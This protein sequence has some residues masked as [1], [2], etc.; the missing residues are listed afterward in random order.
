MEEKIKENRTGGEQ[1]AEM[2]EENRYKYCKI[3]GCANKILK[4]RKAKFCEYHKKERNKE[5]KRE[6]A[7]KKREE[8]QPKEKLEVEQPRPEEPTEEQE[9][10]SDEQEDDEDEDTEKLTGGKIETLEKIPFFNNLFKK[11]KVKLDGIKEQIQ[12]QIE[13]EGFDDIITHQ[14]QDLFPY[15]EELHVCILQLLSNG[16]KET[17]ISEIE[18]LCANSEEV[19]SD[20]EKEIEDI[21]FHISFLYLIKRYVNECRIYIKNAKLILK[22]FIS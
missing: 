10:L 21:A 11:R 19:I 9:T 1:N 18:E 16:E 8:K 4:S 7:R 3:E 14:I 6:Y 13:A 5:S 20:L 17:I 22:E 12:K 2:V 15:I